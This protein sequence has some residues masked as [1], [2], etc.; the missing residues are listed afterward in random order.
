MRGRDYIILAVLVATAI[1]CVIL[2]P[3]LVEARGIGLAAG[4]SVLSGM[5]NAYPGPGPYPMNI[6]DGPNLLPLIF[7]S[8]N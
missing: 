7:F 1:L 2:I 8:G 4:E 3:Q 6:A 5:H